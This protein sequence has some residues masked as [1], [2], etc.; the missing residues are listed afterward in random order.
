MGPTLMTIREHVQIAFPKYK[1]WYCERPRL[2]SP[3][4]FQMRQVFGNVIGRKCIFRLSGVGDGRKI[5]CV[6]VFVR[7]EYFWQF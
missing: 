6:D 3:R 5:D 1:G 4:D 7:A 2:F